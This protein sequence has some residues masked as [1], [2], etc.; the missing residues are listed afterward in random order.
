MDA[1]RVDGD[2]KY[3]MAI[4]SGV[5][6]WALALRGLVAI[7]FALF[8]FAVPGITLAVLVILF[9]AYALVDGVI[10]IVSAVRAAHGHRRWIAFLVEGIVGILAGLVTLFVPAVTFAFL[11]YVVGAWAIVTGVLEIAAAVRLRQ[12]VAG[13]WLLILTGIISVIFGVVVFWAPI[14]GALAIAW[15]LGVYAFIFGILLLVLAFRLRSLHGAT[16]VRA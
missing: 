8:T 11:I 13:E 5:H 4:T 1:A 15:W 14:V 16:P 6:W 10:A 7:L 9:G 12:H 2:T 3:L